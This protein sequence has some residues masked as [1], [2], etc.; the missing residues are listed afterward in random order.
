MP[1]NMIRVE[2]KDEWQSFLVRF[3]IYYPFD[4]R[5]EEVFIE[6]DRLGA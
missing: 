6:V 1:G 2:I 3:S 4:E 5:N